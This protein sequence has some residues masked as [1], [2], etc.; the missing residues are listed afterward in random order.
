MKRKIAS[1]LLL[2]LF[3]VSLPVAA[4]ARADF[5]GRIW[6]NWPNALGLGYYCTAAVNNSGGTT[7]HRAEA[8]SYDSSGKVIAHDKKSGHTEAVAKSGKT[9]P[10]SGLGKYWEE[11]S[12]GKEIEGCVASCPFSSNAYNPS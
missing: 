2:G 3:V 1:L 10:N 12:N 7:T 6:T 11:D 4:F 9:K 5:T 8:W